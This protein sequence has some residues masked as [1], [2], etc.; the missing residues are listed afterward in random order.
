[1]FSETT[2]ETN[3][4]SRAPMKMLRA[5]LVMLDISGY[6]R[7]VKFHATSLLHAEEIIT[8]LLE[9]VIDK[10]EYPLN[11]AK[12]EGDAV[13]LYAEMPAGEEIAAAKSVTRQIGA[14][15]T[16]FYAKEQALGECRH[17]AV[18][19]PGQHIKQLKLKAGWLPA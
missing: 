7:F 16:A 19:E 14:M 11:I 13:F 1:M 5:A 17:G 9:A 4:T 8:E 10:A 6:T 18:L 3:S 2:N 12:L 15:F